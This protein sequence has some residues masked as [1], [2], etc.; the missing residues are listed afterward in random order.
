[1][2]P[3]QGLFTLRQRHRPR[4]GPLHGPECMQ[5]RAAPVLIDQSAG[6]PIAPESDPD[7]VNS[8]QARRAFEAGEGG[9]LAVSGAGSNGV[10]VVG[11]SYTVFTN[12]ASPGQSGDVVISACPINPTSRGSVRA[13][14]TDPRD[15]VVLISNFFGNN[16]DVESGIRCLQAVQGV[17][18]ELTPVLGLQSLVPG[19]GGNITSDVVTGGATS[20]YHYVSGCA[21]GTVVD[22]DFMVMGIEGLR[23]MDAS[24]LPELPP[25]AGPAATVYMIAELAS[26]TIVAA[27]QYTILM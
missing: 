7:V 18:D 27:H 14:S 17:H 24:V 10:S 2:L 23:V 9:V 20:F 1:M 19:P 12:V 4:R 16:A 25:F 21:V 6:V 11:N 8:P 13:S 26:E 22:G 5:A 15:S 3:L